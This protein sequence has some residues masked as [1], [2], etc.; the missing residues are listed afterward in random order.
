MQTPCGTP[1]SDHWAEGGPPFQVLKGPDKTRCLW[2]VPM[3]IPR[4]Q[5]TTGRMLQA[6]TLVSGMPGSDPLAGGA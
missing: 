2:F 1:W 3:S 5:G 4:A 6:Q